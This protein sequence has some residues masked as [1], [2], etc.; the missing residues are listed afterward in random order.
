MQFSKMESEI[1]GVRIAIPEIRILLSAASKIK[2]R[3][4][5]A[6]LRHLPGEPRGTPRGE[7]EA[8][9]PIADRRFDKK[10]EPF[11]RFAAI[12]GAGCRT[13]FWWMQNYFREKCKI[14]GQDF[15]KSAVRK[16]PSLEHAH[17]KRGKP[18]R[19]VVAIDGA[20]GCTPFWKMQNYFREKCKTCGQV[21]GESA[22]RVHD[23][24]PRGCPLGS[25][26]GCRNLAAKFCNFFIDFMG[27]NFANPRG[28]K[29]PHRNAK[30]D[31]PES[32]CRIHKSEKQNFQISNVVFSRRQNA[33]S[34]HRQ[35]CLGRAK[36]QKSIFP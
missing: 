24:W 31:L 17:Q 13:P 18:I 22:V 29:S 32:K 11:L 12:A 25:P 30:T 19:R 26:R 5:A 23:P 34:K 9:G 14:C 10:R 27:I 21:F 28:R 2:K 7:I 36:N 3:T 16:R 20:N 33:L 35:K 1:P 4:L 6:A 8:P 15:G